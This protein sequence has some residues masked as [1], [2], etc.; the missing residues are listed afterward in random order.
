MGALRGLMMRKRMAKSKYYQ[1]PHWRTLRTTALR[2]DNYTCQSCRVSLWKKGSRPTVD[3]IK[4]RPY[5]DHPTPLDVLD[6]LQT[7]CPGCSNRKTEVDGSKG[8]PPPTIGLD[9]LPDDCWMQPG[10][11]GNGLIFS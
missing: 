11:W 2:R 9:G 4:P 8:P 7:L 5:S 1:S 3:H 10:G 6:N